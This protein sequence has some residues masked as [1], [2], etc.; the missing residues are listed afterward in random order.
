MSEQQQQQH[1]EEAL[2]LLCESLAEKGEPLLSDIEKAVLSLW[3]WCGCG[4][5]KDLNAVKG[6]GLGMKETWPELGMAPC[7]FFNRDNAAIMDI[8]EEQ[9]TLDEEEHPQTTRVLEVTESGFAKFLGLIGSLLNHKDDKKGQHNTFRDYCFCVLGRI[10]LFPDVSNTRYATYL[11]AAAEILANLDFYIEYMHYLRDGKGSRT[12][13]NLESNVL[14]GLEDLPTRTELYVLTVYLETISLPIN[15]YLRGVNG[16]NALDMK[17][18]YSD[19]KTQI[20]KIIDNPDLVLSPTADPRLATLNQHES[21]SRPAAMKTLHDHPQWFPCIREVLVGFFGKA[22][23]TWERFMSEFDGEIAELTTIQKELAWM[24]T[25]NDVNEGA[26]GTKRLSSR[27]KPTL[28][29]SQFNA[30]FMYRRNNTQSFMDMYLN[31][32]TS[33]AYLR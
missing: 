22:L 13:N 10:L 5:H 9:Q 24:P 30:M 19:L 17:E 33:L 16:A 32:P 27:N 23:E 3:L 29:L 2:T 4:M 20:K 7:K 11:E 28:T 31:D 15:A 26:L 14:K 18:K 21:W 1:R 25:T 8:A 6:G 12:L